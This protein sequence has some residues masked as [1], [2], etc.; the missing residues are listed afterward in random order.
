MAFL[1]GR[2]GRLTTKNGGFRRGQAGPT[3][4]TATWQAELD[5]IAGVVIQV[6]SKQCR[7]APPPWVLRA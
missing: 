4:E 5:H 6:A 7:A 3:G 1:Y 2:A